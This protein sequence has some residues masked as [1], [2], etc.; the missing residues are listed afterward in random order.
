MVSKHLHGARVLR[1][2]AATL[3]CASLY[4]FQQPARAQAAVADTPA[5]RPAT[6]PAQASPSPSP[7]SPLPSSPL[8]SSPPPSPTAELPVDPYDGG[9]QSDVPRP[10]KRAPV[11]RVLS[12]SG[13]L[14]AQPAAAQACQRFQPKPADVSQYFARARPVSWNA[15]LQQGDWSPC[16]A[17]GELRLTD[18]RMAQW[19]IQ[20]F[21]LGTLRIDGTNHYFSCTERCRITR[22]P[23]SAA[24]L[25]EAGRSP[26]PR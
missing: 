20:S 11:A 5:S 3:V 1:A 6:Q 13:G 26:P 22:L 7:S 25:Q 16:S 10:Y 14:S 2:L 9:P 15:Y 19:R 18:G 4:A 24:A 23:P 17:Q 12:L 8:P 21:G